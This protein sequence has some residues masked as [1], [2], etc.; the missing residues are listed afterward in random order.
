MSD[1][2][3]CMVCGGEVEVVSMC[4]D[5]WQREDACVCDEESEDL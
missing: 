4:L 5:C 1:D 3:G 2:P